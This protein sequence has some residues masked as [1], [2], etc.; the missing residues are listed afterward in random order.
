MQ[1]RGEEGRTK[2][3][4]KWTDT[5]IE[6]ERERDKEEHGG[7]FLMRNKHTLGGASKKGSSGI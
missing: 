5:E 7:R 2:R 6:R 1:V 3:E 4:K